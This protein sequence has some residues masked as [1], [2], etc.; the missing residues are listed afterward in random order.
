MK[1]AVR[2]FALIVVVAGGAAAVSSSSPA[3]AS[4][5]S[6]TSFMPVPA[7]GPNVPTCPQQPA[8]PSHLR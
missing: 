6:A 8:P 4:H 1:L 3:V 7:C 5:L 2:V